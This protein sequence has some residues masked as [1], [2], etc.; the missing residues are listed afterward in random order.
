MYTQKYIYLLIYIYLNYI[1]IYIRFSSSV[2]CTTRST[3]SCG[4]RKSTL[5]KH[6]YL[7]CCHHV[8]EF[9]MLIDCQAQN[10]IT[11]FYVETLAGCKKTH[12]QLLVSVTI[13]RSTSFASVCGLTGR[14]VEHDAYGRR[15]VNDVGPIVQIVHVIAAVVATVTKHQIQHQVLWESPNMG[16]G[17]QKGQRHDNADVQR[18]LSAD[19]Q[20]HYSITE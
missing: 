18:Q 14:Q 15:V 1:N 9:G 20:P 19:A 3:V 2:F 6:T 13:S 11:V 7:A 5:H 17:G 8:G 4:D 10:V 12:T 16:G